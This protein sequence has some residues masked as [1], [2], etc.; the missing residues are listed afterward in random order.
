[1]NKSWIKVLYEPKLSNPTFIQGLSL[2]DQV[3]ST[4]TRLLLEHANPKKFAEFYSPY[5]PDYVSAEGNGL[6][7]LPRYEFYTNNQPEP[8]I[9]L[10][11][12]N[13]QSLPEDSYSN[14]EIFTTIFNYAKKVGCN[15]FMSYGGFTPEK[16]EDA[17]YVAATSGRLALNIVKKFGG[18]VFTQGRI[19]GSIGLILGLANSQGLKG[20]CIL[21]PVADKVPPEVAA[22]P[23]F[24]YILRILHSK[25]E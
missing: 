10:L 7:S 8:N 11:A 19:S 4:V 20:V 25:R 23:V 22:L 21:R 16:A 14:Y 15:K 2:S 3:S 17:I 9:I 12:G 18:K 13:D 1:M 24:N 6:C 5:F